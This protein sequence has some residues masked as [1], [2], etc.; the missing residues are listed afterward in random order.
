MSDTGPEKLADIKEANLL[1][2]KLASAG[3]PIVV[4]RLLVMAQTSDDPEVVRRIAETLLKFASQFTE[5][6]D[7]TVYQPAI[8]TFDFGSGGA[9][10]EFKPSDVPTPAPLE[11]VEELTC[12]AAP[13]PEFLPVPDEPTLELPI[14]EP[15][16]VDLESRLLQME[17]E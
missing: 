2:A 14:P 13:D 5:K 4:E 9:T 17:D 3:G 6:K 11:F 15:V 16:M 12:T 1:A 7:N 10:I 8:V